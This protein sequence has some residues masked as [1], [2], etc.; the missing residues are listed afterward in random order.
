M[1]FLVVDV[2][3]L[4]VPQCL[5]AWAFMLMA[6]VWKDIA[7]AASGVAVSL[8]FR[9]GM[10][11]M[12][13]LLLVAEVALTAVASPLLS[14]DD[15]EGLILYHIGDGLLA[16]MIVGLAL[17]GFRA[18]WGMLALLRTYR[19]GAGTGRCGRCCADGCC[20]W[21]QPCGLATD[22]LC[23]PIARRER[24]DW[25]G[26][27]SA[28]AGGPA[29]LEADTFDVVYEALR[30][31]TLGM[32][33]GACMSAVLITGVVAETALDLGTST[34]PNGYLVFLSVFLMCEA[35]GGLLLASMSWPRSA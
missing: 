6:V 27:S 25:A 4:R 12:G 15:T 2:M 16:L 23:T 34:T 9:C 31:T 19:A 3:L 26:P 28:L 8:R 5:W 20:R 33:G 13:A 30:Q 29:E 1:A 10:N 32:L 18:V 21:L 14:T 17:A 22:L 24:R 7:A 11:A 35:V